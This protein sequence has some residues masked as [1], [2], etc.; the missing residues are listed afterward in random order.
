VDCAL[1]DDACLAKCVSSSGCRTG[2][3]SSGDEA[4]VSVQALR[5]IS[6][7]RGDHTETWSC[8]EGYYESALGL[9]ITCPGED[10]SFI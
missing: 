8:T 2:Y 9:E 5:G 10:E 7:V 4:G 6:G 1:G 3:G